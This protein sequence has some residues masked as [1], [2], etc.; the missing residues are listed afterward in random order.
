MNVTQPDA[1]SLMF[2]FPYILNSH[3]FK[4]STSI[5]N[6][7]LL[8]LFSHIEMCWR[9]TFVTFFFREVVA[10]I[11]QYFHQYKIMIDENIPN[12][13][14]SSNQT[15]ETRDTDRASGNPKL[16]HAESAL[17]FHGG[18]GLNGSVNVSNNLVEDTC[19]KSY[20][21]RDSPHLRVHRC[22]PRD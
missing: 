22:Y 10:I 4:I 14:N 12:K 11:S 13:W 2:I 5:L 21:G 15:R 9:T 7:S 16:S 20:F 18:D 19:G 8:Y 3:L 1:T 6:M 17:Y